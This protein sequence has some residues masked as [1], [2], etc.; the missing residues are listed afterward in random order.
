[1]F[2]SNFLFSKELAFNSNIL[3]YTSIAPFPNH[4]QYFKVR[5]S[6]LFG[7]PFE[8][9]SSVTCMESAGTSET[10]DFVATKLHDVTFQEI[11]IFT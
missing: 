9:I 4:I 5:L 8:I 7:L 2:I 3:Q 11:L 6:T 1:M 10:T